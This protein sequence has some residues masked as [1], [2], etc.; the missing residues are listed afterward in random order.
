VKAKKQKVKNQE[1]ESWKQEKQ[2]PPAQDAQNFNADAIG[3]LSLVK[4]PELLAKVTGKERRTSCVVC[5]R[6]ARFIN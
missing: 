2:N 3:Y 1:V 6:C 5:L 4:M